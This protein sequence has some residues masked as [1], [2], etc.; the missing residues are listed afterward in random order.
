MWTTIIP[1]LSGHSLSILYEFGWKQPSDATKEFFK[2][3][4][5]FLATLESS[6][7]TTP[8]IQ[9]VLIL[10]FSSL[11]HGM[12]LE[13]AWLENNMEVWYPCTLQKLTPDM[14]HLLKS[15]EETKKW[16][17]VEQSVRRLIGPWHVVSTKFNFDEIVLFD[18]FLDTFKVT[19]C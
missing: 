12:K 14:Y 17:G 8:D 1:S 2:S 15:P 7:M 19:E 3:P 13:V 10:C 11:H 6:N 16:W 5:S 9:A 4:D 18:P